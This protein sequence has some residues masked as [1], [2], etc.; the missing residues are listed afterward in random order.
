[1]IFVAGSMS[2]QP[3]HIDEFEAAVA[4]MVDG[5]REEDG[6]IHYSLLVENRAAGL[7]NV[8]EMWES[9]EKLKTHLQ[10]AG[11]QE[12]FGRF[13]PLMTGMNVQVYD[14]LNPRGVPL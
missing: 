9:E 6:C 13:G 1:M 10:T 11:T 5:V 2:V 7:V 12:F 4:A 14:A 8:L 3:A